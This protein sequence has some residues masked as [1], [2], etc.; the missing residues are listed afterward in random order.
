[1]KNEA[2]TVFEQELIAG[3]KRFKIIDEKFTGQVIL[4]CNEG[5]LCDFEKIEKSLKKKMEGKT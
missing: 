2:W 5:G 4:H 1:M 3:L